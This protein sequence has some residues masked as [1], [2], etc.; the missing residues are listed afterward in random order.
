MQIQTGMFGEFTDSLKRW[1]QIYILPLQAVTLILV[2]HKA[3]FFFSQAHWWEKRASCV[4]REKKKKKSSRSN[5][6][7]VSENAGR[8]FTAF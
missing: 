5:G 3:I 4:L 7:D 6:F 8:N 1:A 2:Y